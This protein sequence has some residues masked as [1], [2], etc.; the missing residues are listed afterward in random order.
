MRAHDNGNWSS[1]QWNS[2]TALEMIG[3]L[4]L[5]IIGQLRFDIIGH[6]GSHIIGQMWDRELLTRLCH[7]VRVTRSVEFCVHWRQRVLARDCRR[8]ETP[9]C[10]KWISDECSMSVEVL[11][12]WECGIWCRNLRGLSAADELVTLRFLCTVTR[13]RS[14]HV[15]GQRR[16]ATDSRFRSCFASVSP[17]FRNDFKRSFKLKFNNYRF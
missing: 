16:F 14:S 1:D 12:F 11:D 9:L 10:R 5:H 6:N 8:W 15:I 4:S 2:I 7:R 3:Q 17:L 13:W